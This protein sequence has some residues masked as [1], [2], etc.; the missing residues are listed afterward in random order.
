MAGRDPERLL[1]SSGN[2]LLIAL[3]I[4]EPHLL[5]GGAG[6]D[7]ASFIRIGEPIIGLSGRRARARRN[8]DCPPIHLRREEA[9]EG[10]RF[11]DVLLGNDGQNSFLGRQGRDI[12]RGRGGRDSI[13]ARDGASDL[14]IDCGSGRDRLRRDRRDP[15]GRSC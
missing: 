7:T 2:D 13:D 14:L 1:G 10:T 6:I 4:C 5:E 12:F 11:G 3:T 15:L 8:A 9:I